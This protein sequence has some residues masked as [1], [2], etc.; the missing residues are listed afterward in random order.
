MTP[1]LFVYGS[2]MPSC[3]G[4]F[5]KSMRAR[6][7]NESTLLGPATIQGQLYDLGQYPALVQHPDA[8]GL[9]HGEVLTLAGPAT[10]F[11]W[12]DAFEGIV[13]SRSGGNEYLRAERTI[14]LAA[15]QELQA[16]IYIYTQ[17]VSALVPIP[18]G[19]WT[20]V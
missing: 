9:V 3:R 17:D 4:S 20:A 19:R 8:T 18:S 15:G 10:T 14:K 6:L 5:G 16:W 7:L 11:A 1:T 12:L 13:P 2:L